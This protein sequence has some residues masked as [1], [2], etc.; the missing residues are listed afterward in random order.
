MYVVLAITEPEVFS[1]Q[2]DYLIQLRLVLL[3]KV[4]MD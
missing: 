3:A 2:G 1:K 4:L